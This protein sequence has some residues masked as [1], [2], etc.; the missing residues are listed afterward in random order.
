MREFE[1]ILDVLSYRGVDPDTA[2]CIEQLHQ[3]LGNSFITIYRTGLSPAACRSI[4]ATR[5]MNDYGGKITAPYM[6]FVDDDEIFNPSDVTRL[7]QGLSSGKRC[8]GGLYATRTG[9]GFAS[10]GKEVVIDGDIHP[11]DWL[12]TGFMGIDKT[13]LVDVKDKLK[14]P[15][16]NPGEWHE[17]Y[18]F[19]VYCYGDDPLKNK[20][21]FFSEDYEFC[22]KLHEAGET[23]YLDTSIQVGHIGRKVY[24]VSD[25]TEYEKQNHAM[26]A[27]RHRQD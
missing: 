13:L 23:I 9:K 18:P 5:F 3:V 22:R 12:A 27:D 15:L 8:I 11:C 26:V 1:F 4:E 24:N 10:G 20:M 21:D 7:L 17:C 19:F 16:L 2:S 14:L 6:I 25:V